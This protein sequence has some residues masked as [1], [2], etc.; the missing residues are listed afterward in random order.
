ML[1][2]C[3]NQW[4]E[5]DTQLERKEKRR[6]KAKKRSMSKEETSETRTIQGARKSGTQ[7][8]NKRTD[9]VRKKATGSYQ[10]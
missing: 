2:S 10:R 4:S 8:Q 1:E 6:D 3:T 5:D 9:K 7:K